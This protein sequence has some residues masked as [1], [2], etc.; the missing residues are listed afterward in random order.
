MD[1]R[2]YIRK[3]IKKENTIIEFGPLNRP[4]FTKKEFPNIY[5]ADNRNTE[6]IKKLYS[7]NEYLEK[8]GISVDLNTI[9]DIDYVID[10]TYKKTFGCK[11]FDIA[12]LSHVV[13][14]MP[15]IIRFFEEISDILNYNGRLI[16][17]YPDKRY[18]FDHYRNSA[19]FRDAY[20][21]YKNGVKENARLS[22][23]F[24]YNAIKENDAI[25]F[26]NNDK[27]ITEISAETL[28]N[29]EKSYIMNLNGKLEDDVHFWPFSDFDFLKFIYEMQRANLLDFEIDEFFPTQENTQEFLIILKKVKIENVD[30]NKTTEL[31]STFDDL[32]MIHQNLQ[33]QR[34]LSDLK[35]EI[36]EIKEIINN[37]K[38][39]LIECNQTIKEL[40][41]NIININNSKSMKITKPLRIIKS[42][43]LGGDKNE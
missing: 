13:E 41:Q 5:Y 33:Y 26:W 23:D 25:K 37:L 10:D 14:H 32:N 21:T 35:K 22:F 20:S 39:T 4:L 24:A 18:C 12:Y 38:Q 9:V 31:I 42:K 30:I 43:F 29:A 7:G 19:S 16:L 1:F 40:N 3:N 27:I 6:S 2:K 15:D 36:K 8:T 11:K 17:I 28:K 34:E